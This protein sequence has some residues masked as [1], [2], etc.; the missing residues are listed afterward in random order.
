MVSLLIV[1]AAVEFVVDVSFDAISV[2]FARVHRICSCFQKSLMKSLK[3]R[4]CLKRK[5]LVS[6]LMLIMMK[7]KRE[8]LVSFV[9]SLLKRQKKQMENVLDFDFWL[10]SKLMLMMEMMLL[11][12][13]SEVVVVVSELILLLD[14]LFLLLLVLPLVADLFLDSMGK[15]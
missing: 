8:Q 5:I 1:V 15:L 7:K 2:C 3:M 10:I 9:G 6:Q 14:H 12:V 4:M 13:F 11:V